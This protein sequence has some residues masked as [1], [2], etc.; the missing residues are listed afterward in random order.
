M[1]AR[2]QFRFSNNKRKA[3]LIE[4]W[5]SYVSRIA[6]VGESKQIILKE[7]G[8]PQNTDSEHIWIWVDDYEV[9][10]STVGISNWVAMSKCG[11]DGFF[12]LFRD[13]KAASPL[14]AF[15]AFDA[16]AKYLEII[17]ES[18]DGSR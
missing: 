8:A 18:P 5:R 13:G 2:L 6:R 14:M 11:S 12:I 15:S 4:K 16:P 3:Q 10:A 9:V 17:G 1:Y 7:I